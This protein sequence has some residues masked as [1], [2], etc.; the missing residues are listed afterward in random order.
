[1]IKLFIITAVFLL[2][3]CSGTSPETEFIPY[4]Q[5]YDECS[6]DQKTFEKMIVCGKNKRLES[7]ENNVCSGARGNAFMSYSDSLLT[8]VKSGQ[9]S[10]EEAKRRWIEFRLK[11]ED[12]FIKDHNAMLTR[13]AIHNQSAGPTSTQCHTANGYTNC[14]SF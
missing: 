14:T 10:E 8:S 12:A 6:Q 1:M 3:A 9:L 2:S 4:W 7:C 5:H 13:R 11:E